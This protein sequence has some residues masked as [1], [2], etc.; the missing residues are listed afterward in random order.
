MLS[1]DESHA[2][3]G[4]VRLMTE[5]DGLLIESDEMKWKIGRRLDMLKHLEGAQVEE[6]DNAEDVVKEE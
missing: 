3:P 2:T 1:L 6:N 5:G 4:G